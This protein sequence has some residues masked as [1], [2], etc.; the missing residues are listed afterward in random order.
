MVRHSVLDSWKD[1]RGGEIE[2]VRLDNGQLAIEV[3][4]LGG[5]IRSLWAPDNRGERANLVLG[6]DSVEDYL[7]QNAHLGAIAGRYANRIA[8][9]KLHYDGEDFQLDVNQATNCLH[10]GREGFN[11][12]QWTLGLLPDGV[13]LSLRSPDGDMGFP[14]NCSVQLDYRLAGNNLYVEIMAM[15]D[16]PCPVNLT[17]H[18]YF[19]LDGRA[20]CLDHTV[21]M[22]AKTFLRCNEA[23]IPTGHASTTGTPLSLQDAR[24][25][26][27]VQ[28]PDLASTR[29]FDH[30]F[31]I[32]KTQD[33]LAL[34]AELHS[35]HSGRLLKLYTNQPGV[36]LYGA[37]FLDGERGRQ[38]KIYRPYQGVCLEPQ[39][40][41]DAPNQPDLGKA[42][43]M[44][45]EIYHHI[46]RYQFEVKD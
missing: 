5:I 11:R 43:L 25:G 42:W 12:K 15:T 14:G 22:H 16:K 41:P 27:R 23:G 31:V 26:D 38:G 28:H 32:D 7:T 39:L 4:S 9:G 20:D 13:R 40:F 37:N 29:G 6:C 24:L 36:Q 10:G 17:Q 30:C 18:S 33:E 19:N 1:P 3:L 46:S 8:H 21:T 35:P 45:G 44:P 2:R 34:A